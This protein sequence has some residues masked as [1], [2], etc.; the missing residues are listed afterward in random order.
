M[1]DADLFALILAVLYL[2]EC[3]HF[4]SLNSIGLL[5]FV[6]RRARL[7]FPNPLVGRGRRG[8]LVAWPLPPLGDLFL[9]RPWPIAASPD[10]I[11]SYTALCLHPDGRATQDAVVQAIDEIRSIETEDKT[12]FL[13]GKPFF[14][15]DSPPSASVVSRFISQLRQ[16]PHD[17]R[18]SLID[19]HL[20]SMFDADAIRTRL[21]IY[22]GTTRPLRLATNALFVHLLVV[23]PISLLSSQFNRFWMPLMLAFVGLLALTLTEFWRAHKTLYPDES[24]ERK[25]SVVFMSLLWLAA[26]RALDLLSRR[27]LIAHHPLAAAKILCAPE[28]FRALALRVWRDAQ[29]PLLP[30]HPAR[31]SELA[32]VEIWSRER[33][34]RALEKFLFSSGFARE[35]L[36]AA[37]AIIDTN[38]SYCPRCHCQY[39]L[40]EGVCRDCGGIPLRTLEVEN[41]KTGR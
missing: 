34:V 33:F 2:S 25:Q 28:D 29:C 27:L 11:V 26:P 35:E 5:C 21:E 4:A 38:L 40:K 9:P 20:G 15:A 7:F 12:V 8:F 31:A 23:T 18:A 32:I 3:F 17:A 39:Y 1:S 22:R 19:N 16:T 41:E 24:A 37:P 14:H 6:G 13:N 36:D 10:A 30:I